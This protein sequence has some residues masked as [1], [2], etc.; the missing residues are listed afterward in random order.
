MNVNVPPLDFA[1]RIKMHFPPGPRLRFPVSADEVRG[2]VSVAGGQVEGPLLSGEVVAGSGGDWP[3]FRSDGVVAFDARYLIR[4][5]DGT[6]IQVFNR[7]YA[8]APADVQAR[9]ERGQPV[10][11]SE[12]YFRVAP[13][14]E[15][16]PGPHDWLTRT[17]F[18]G[19]GEKHADHSFFDFFAVR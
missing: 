17:V 6:I 10:D 5:V 1:F 15:T 9:I 12:N 18:V 19:F 16:E 13:V 3:L 2:F 11:P 4:A 14:F 8:H 7:G